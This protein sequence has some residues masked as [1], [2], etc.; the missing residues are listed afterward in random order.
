MVFQKEKMEY[1]RTRMLCGFLIGFVFWQIPML[2][3]SLWSNATVKLI[4]AFVSPISV[5]G[6]VV[7]MYYLVQVVRFGFM[8]RKHPEMG[9]KFN[10]ERIQQTRLKSF[11]AGF[12]VL[13]VLQPILMYLAPAT[14]M[15]AEG[16]VMV[17]IFFAVTSVLVAVLILER[18]RSDEG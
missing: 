18:A 9:K 1:Y 6:G 3:T 5:I 8:L 13:V 15:T 10:D 12:W 16:V 2:L 7:W 4:A 17:N 11:T 14:D